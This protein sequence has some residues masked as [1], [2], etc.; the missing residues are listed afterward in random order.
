MKDLLILK[1]LVLVIVI[2][3]VFSSFNSINGIFIE[4]NNSILVK[5]KL[6]SQFEYPYIEIWNKTFGGKNSD[7]CHS[8]WQ[9][10]DGGYIMIG[11]TWSYG[12]G[13]RD[14]WFIKTDEYGNELWNKTF[15]GKNKEYSNSAKQTNDCG[16]IITGET[17]SYGAG[18]YDVWLIKID[19]CGNEI[20][21]KTFGGKYKDYSESVQ[22]TSDGGYIITGETMSY[23][24]GSWDIWLIKTDEYGNELWNKTFGGSNSDS[25]SSLQITNDDGYIITGETMSYGA[26]SWDI[27]LIRLSSENKFKTI[28]IT[29]RITDKIKMDKIITFKAVNII[30]IK[31]F[32]IQLIQYSSGERMIVLKLYFGIIG[33][34]FIFGFFRFSF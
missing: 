1:K 14:I 12:V 10:S 7:F 25:G 6:I 29:G 19:E 17:L 8:I 5:N 21:N 15:G 11:D 18:N 24:A 23:G 33:S 32:P 31:Y 30:G 4:E 13:Y 20:W 16:Y 9:T 26:G 3:L 22:Q 28:F 34:N 2:I 27:W